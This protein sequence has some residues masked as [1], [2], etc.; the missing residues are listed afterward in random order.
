M[1]YG[2]VMSNL[3]DYADPRVVVS[4]ARAAEEAAWQALRGHH[5]R[6]SAGHTVGDRV[7]APPT[8]RFPLPAASQKPGTA[9][10]PLACCRPGHRGQCPCEPALPSGGRVGIPGLDWGSCRG[11]HRFRLA[12]PATRKERARMLDEG[13]TVLHGLSSAEP[14][15]HHNGQHD[16]VENVSMAPLPPQRSAQSHLDRR[17]GR[18]GPSTAPPVGDW[19]RL[20]AGHEARWDADPPHSTLARLPETGRRDLTS[21]RRS[22]R[23]RVMGLPQA[24]RRP[25]T[26]RVP[27][28][29]PERPG[30]WK[31]TP[32]IRS[33]G[34][35]MAWRETGA[36]ED[37]QAQMSWMTKRPYSHLSPASE[38]LASTPGPPE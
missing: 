5:L 25:A 13:L 33:G 20:C 11:V 36:T 28:R 3:D 30:G 34:G 6:A 12:S 7:S 22:S 27:M 37:E 1:R 21:K 4:L 19:L 14:L 23:W 17:P 8:S 16:H 29:W 18:A 32:R 35:R 15:A 2:I 31:N 9:I 38:E 26:R 10:T 24:G